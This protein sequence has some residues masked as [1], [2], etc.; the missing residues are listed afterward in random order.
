MSYIGNTLPA[1][2]QSLPAVQRFNGNASTTAFTLAAA[3]ANDQSILVSVDGVVQD[4][5]AYSVSGT[6]LTFTAAP[7]SGTG[8]IFVNTIS[9]VGST[10]VPPDGIA[11]NATTGTFSDGLTVDDDGTTPLIV[12]R[13]SSDGTIIEIHKDGS[14]KGKIGNSGNDPYIGRNAGVGLTFQNNKIRPADGDDG[15]GYDN[16]VDLGEPTYRFKDLYLSSGVFLGGTGSANELDD[17]EE[18]IYGATISCASGSITLDSTFNELAYTKVGRVVH[19]QGFLKVGSVS[20]PTGAT[21]LNLPF[22]AADLS[23]KAGVAD[24]VCFS[25]LNGSAV[26]NG[27]Y[28]LFCELGENTANNRIFWD[29]NNQGNNIGD[30]VTATGSTL[31]MNFS[32]IA[33]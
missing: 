20:S 18:G 15:S 11:I 24:N 5:N 29:N 3:I 33:A 7:S 16:A 30:N 23:D 1:N 22:T 25:Y 19:V 8:N 17:Y 13:A 32:Y 6:T 14:V 4:S 12:D 28:I 31:R 9:P 21:N 10:L 27:Y 26:T 2:F